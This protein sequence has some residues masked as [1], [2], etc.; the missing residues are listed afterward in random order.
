VNFCPG[1]K[2]YMASLPDD[3]RKEIVERYN[4]PP[5]KFA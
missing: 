1:W 3:Q 2:G 4:F 5:T